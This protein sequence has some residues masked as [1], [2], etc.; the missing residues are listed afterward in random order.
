MTEYHYFKFLIKNERYPVYRKIAAFIF[1]LNA[2]ALFYLGLQN[3]AFIS[4]FSLIVIGI[5]FL[6]YSLF[7]F[8]SKINT[9]K[10]YITVYIIGAIIWYTEVGSLFPCLVLLGL[11]ALQVLTQ[12]SVTLAIDKEGVRL[13]SYTSKFYPWAEI[14][15][16][17]LKDGLLSIDLSSNKLLQLEPDLNSAVTVRKGGS[18]NEVKWEVGEDYPE[19]EF[20]VKAIF[21]RKHN[22][23]SI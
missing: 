19:L 15:N 20:A 22:N 23:A 5:L 21:L 3:K 12:T 1:L 17:V 6:V 14:S 4:R 11:M 8:F 18:L 13:K 9:D 7:S 16:L 10:S 2:L